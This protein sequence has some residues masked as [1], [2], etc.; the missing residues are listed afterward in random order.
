MLLKNKI[1]PP[2][3]L[4]HV[5]VE[6][7]KTLHELSGQHVIYELCELLQGGLLAD[8]M[9]NTADLISIPRLI[10]EDDTDAPALPGAIVRIISS[11]L[12][13]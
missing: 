7:M 9:A 4:M 8:I 3:I 2:A 13:L 10:P 11:S 5:T 1:L 6:L 12:P